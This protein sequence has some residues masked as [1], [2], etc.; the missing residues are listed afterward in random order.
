MVTPAVNKARPI[1]E[2]KSPSLVERVGDVEDNLKIYFLPEK[3]TL[4]L[5]VR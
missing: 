3:L 4:W 5:E 2:S 1:L